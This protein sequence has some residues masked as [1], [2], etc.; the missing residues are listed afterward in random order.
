MK[1][2]NILLGVILF[3]VLSSTA[4][5]QIPFNF[6]GYNYNV[7]TTY[8]YSP[9]TVIVPINPSATYSTYYTPRVRYG[10]VPVYKQRLVR[11]APLHGFHWLR[12]P[13]YQGYT[14]WTFQPVYR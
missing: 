7:T 3:T 4:Y 12:K 10:W 5:S 13:V 2:F 1:T 11:P 14:E 9:P 6:N 8:S